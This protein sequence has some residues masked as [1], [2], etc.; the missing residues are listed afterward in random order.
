[1]VEQKGEPDAVK[2]QIMR[3]WAAL[4]QAFREPGL[5]IDPAHVLTSETTAA[6][7]VRNRLRAIALRKLALALR[8]VSFPNL[9]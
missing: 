1:V 8:F 7:E 4:R 2:R 3:L 6:N 9:P 5:N